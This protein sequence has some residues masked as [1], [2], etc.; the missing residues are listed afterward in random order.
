M[1]L[2]VKLMDTTVSVEDPTISEPSNDREYAE[3]IEYL[4]KRLQSMNEE[5]SEKQKKIEQSQ[6]ETLTMLAQ[7]KIG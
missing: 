2:E 5:M 6:K 7:L 3:A 4:L 1:Q